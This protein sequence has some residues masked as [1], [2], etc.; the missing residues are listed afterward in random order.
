MKSMILKIFIFCLACSCLR[1]NTV[2]NQ[3]NFVNVEFTAHDTTY[4][5]L[6]DFPDVMLEKNINTLIKGLISKNC[7]YGKA[8]GFGG[9]YTKEYA[10]FERL[11][12]L[13]N[14]KEMFALIDH[15]NPVVRIY[16][17]NALKI[18]GSNYVAEANLKLKN[19]K[20]KVC[21]FEGCIKI[22]IPLNQLLDN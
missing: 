8:V 22:S 13:L 18:D 12:E 1:N 6:R 9:V 16:A 10:C 11:N 14:D 21:S 17:Y 20:T 7:V 3:N 2:H 19:D 4:R 5:D 15:L